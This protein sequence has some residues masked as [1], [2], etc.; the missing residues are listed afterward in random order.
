MRAFCSQLSSVVFG[1]SRQTQ[2]FQNL[3]RAVIGVVLVDVS[4]EERFQGVLF[5]YRGE[6]EE[7][8]TEAS[9][10]GLVF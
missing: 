6:L 8:N 10:N 1:F 2:C 3:F 7:P 9:M 5:N 4:Q